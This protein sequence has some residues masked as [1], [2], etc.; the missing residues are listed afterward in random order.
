MNSQYVLD[1]DAM[2]NKPAD[3][4]S[5]DAFKYMLSHKLGRK[6]EAY[7]ASWPSAA[8]LGAAGDLGDLIPALAAGAWEVN[9]YHN[10]S[11]PANELIVWA[12]SSDGA[13]GKTAEQAAAELQAYLASQ[14]HLGVMWVGR[15]KTDPGVETPYGWAI[16]LIAVLPR[17][18]AGSWSP[19]EETYRT[20]F[21]GSMQAWCAAN[22]VRFL[23]PSQDTRLAD[24][25]NTTYYVDQHYLTAA[26]K[27]VVAD[28]VH[29]LL[30]V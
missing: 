30:D 6:W 9:A 28:Q 24:C 13:A 29:A 10:T 2:F 22:N 12:G 26:G 21:N 3:R 25:S 5:H 20:A 8:D 23:D 27:Q 4:D 18:D 17:G 7:D 15:T 1:G 14:L 11:N 19:D 16:T